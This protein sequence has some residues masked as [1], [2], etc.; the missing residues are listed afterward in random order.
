MNP[1]KKQKSF[2][3]YANMMAQ[4]Q[5]LKSDIDIRKSAL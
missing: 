1:L 4:A 3:L 5:H 2:T